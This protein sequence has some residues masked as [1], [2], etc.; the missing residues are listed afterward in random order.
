MRRRRLFLFAILVVLGADIARSLLTRV[1]VR[2]P[3]S[4]AAIITT[5][6]PGP[7]NDSP[8]LQL[9][10]SHC[11]RCHGAEGKGD[12]PAAAALRP[13]PRDFTGGIFKLKSTPSGEPPTAQDVSATI[14]HGMPGSAMPGFDDLLSDSEIDALSEHIRSLGPHA[15]WS[16]QERAVKV[17][18]GEGRAQHGAELFVDLGCPAC[19]G[20][21]GKGDGASAAALKD[22]WQQPA[23]PRDLSA[24]WTFRGRSSRDAIYQ[25]IAHGMSGT[26]M[27]GYLDAASPSDILDVVAYI[28]SLA[29][30]PPWEEGAEVDATANP[31]DPVKRGEY[32]VRTGMCAMCHGRSDATGT[33][34]DLAG[35]RKIDAGAHG[36]F[37]AANLTSDAESGIGNRKVE[38]LAL[39]LQSGHTRSGRLSYLAMPWIIYGSLDPADALAIAAYL[40]TLPTVRNFVPRALHYGFAETVLRKLAYNWPA[41]LPARVSYGSTNF[42]AELPERWGIAGLLGVLIWL[43]V[44]ALVI[45]VVSLFRVAAPAE[46]EGRRS[47]AV[48]LTSIVG[49]VVAGA[50]ALTVY[51]YPAL[52]ALPAKP[53]VDAF[54]SS[55]PPVQEDDAAAL[56]RGRYLYLTSSCAY[57]HNGNGSGGGKVSGRGI[58]SVWAS[59]L[60]NNATGLAGLSDEIV[61]RAIVSGIGSSG[62]P[63]DPRVMPWDRYSNLAAADQHALLAYLRALPSIERRV[64]TPRPP[65]PDDGGDDVTFWIGAERD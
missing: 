6:A 42:G 48:L 13:R 63:I 64:P 15:A 30:R 45:G 19:H 16:A 12:G 59:N 57:C 1:A 49:A 46:D 41:A 34:P 3:P 25:R 52:N 11:A 33:A 14:R 10:L 56:R 54:A 43:Q 5:S 26:P 22:V 31:A 17:M 60:T 65:R 9:F 62:H 24:P 58:G 23:P 8:G 27:A 36:I 55:V 18:E 21:D 44:A 35:G 40:K 29:R 20:K 32:L 37:F 7:R 28:R 4:A 51:W 47:S 39:A 2:T 38:E 61:V 53:L 50:A